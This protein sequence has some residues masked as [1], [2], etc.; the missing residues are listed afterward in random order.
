MPIASCTLLYEWQHTHTHT[1]KMQTKITTSPYTYTLTH[2]FTD[3]L[4][5]SRC[6]ANLQELNSSQVDNVL[7]FKILSEFHRFD[8]YKYT[9]YI[10]TNPISNAID[11]TLKSM[12]LH[13]IFKVQVLCSIR[14]SYSDKLYILPMS[15]SYIF[16]VHSDDL[17]AHTHTRRQ[18]K[19]TM[20]Q[21]IF[22]SYFFIVCSFRLTPDLLSLYSSSKWA[23]SYL[24][25]NISSWSSST[26]MKIYFPI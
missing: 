10:W 19:N 16:S 20:C 4:S 25:L 2:L 3:A 12:L 6:T 7:S 22:I 18:K 23:N 13:D 17:W 8:A 21:V 1:K 14:A 24:D 15:W 11:Y 9:Y 5:N 26:S